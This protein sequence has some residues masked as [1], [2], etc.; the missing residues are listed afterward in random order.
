[1]INSWDALFTLLPDPMDYFTGTG[2]QLPALPKNLLLF[3]KKTFRQLCGERANFFHYRYVLTIN[4]GNFQQIMVDSRLQNL[5]NQSA[6]LV[7]PHQFH[8][9]IDPGPGN[10]RMLFMTFELDPVHSLTELRNRVVGLDRSS[11]FLIKALGKSYMDRKSGQAKDVSILLASLL[12]CNLLK[13]LDN[14]R[15]KK[16]QEE[17]QRDTGKADR[18]RQKLPDEIRAAGEIIFNNPALNIDELAAQVARSEGHLRSLFRKHL[19]ISLGSYIL[20]VRTNRARQ[21]LATS[22]RTMVD[23]AQICG[24]ENVY[25][26][27]RMFKR[28]TGISPGRFR[29]QE[30]SP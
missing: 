25:S 30:G 19:G 23:I 24:Y 16:L 5:Q 29:Q 13:T 26:F 15:H 20:E 9:F 17:G 12:I 22:K 28:E 6:I 8:R 3:G 18:G 7:F 27:S 14:S 21:L 11:I 4:L 2:E 1:M 10:M